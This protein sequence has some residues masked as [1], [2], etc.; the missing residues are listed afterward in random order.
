VKTRSYRTG[1]RAR[2]ILNVLA[3]TALSLL[4]LALMLLRQNGLFLAA[5]RRARG[6]TIAAA[7]EK[8]LPALVGAS[9]SVPETGPAALALREL[10]GTLAADPMIDSV[11]LSNPAG[12]VVASAFRTAPARE[13]MT[14]TYPLLSQAAPVGTLAVSFS[15]REIGRQAAYAH[16]QVVLQLGITAI[17]LVVFLHLYLSLA[18]LHPVRRLAEATVR[19]AE[20]DLDRPVATGRRDELGDLAAAFESMRL[21]LRQSRE[22]NQRQLASIRQANAD[23]LAKEEALVRSERMAAVGRVAAGVAHEVGNPLAAVTGYLALLHRGDLPPGEA[24]EYLARTEREVA[25]IN[26][27]MLDLLDWARPPR[28][29]LAAVEVNALL[30]GLAQHLGTQP[31]FGAVTLE[32]S[33][34]DGLRPAWADYHHARQLLLNLALNAAQAMPGGGRLTLESF[35]PEDPGFAAGVRVRDDGPGIPAAVAAHLFEP[36]VTAAKGRRGTGLGLAICR[37]AAEAMGATI[38]VETAPGAGTTFTVLLAAP[39]GPDPAPRTGTAPAG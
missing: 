36:F 30:R 4:L 9:G 18:L 5:E 16:L 32:L 28:V 38:T 3:I 22:V 24:A 14:F 23:L 31:D 2:L 10:L 26:R 39:P 19:I 29:E 17:V 15:A 20:G 21:S 12:R 25:R 6:A 1:I 37:R 27:I 33:L 13:G 35:R 11:T 7:V 8:T 34:A